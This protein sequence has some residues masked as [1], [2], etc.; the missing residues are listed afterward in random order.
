MALMLLRY[1][2]TKQSTGG[3]YAAKTWRK[4][5]EYRCYLLLR[6]GETKQSTGGTNVTKT[7]R[8]KAEYIQVVLVTRIWGQKAKYRWY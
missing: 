7:C 5:A 8:K 6:Y 1:G 3:T 4:K 2:E